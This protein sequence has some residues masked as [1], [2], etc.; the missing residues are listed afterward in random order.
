MK[1]SVHSIEINCYNFLVAKNNKNEWEREANIILVLG[2]ISKLF[3]HSKTTIKFLGSKGTKKNSSHKPVRCQV[4]VKGSY[5][6]YTRIGSQPKKLGAN[7]L[8]S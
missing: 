3:S 8:R 7:G 5:L 4:L 6:N 2:S 1:N